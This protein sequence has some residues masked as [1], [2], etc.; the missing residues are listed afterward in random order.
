MIY[1]LLGRLSVG[2]PDREVVLREKYVR[3]LVALM[4]N[5]NHPVS[6]S[7]LLD[8]GWSADDVK[9]AQLDKAI[10]A[11]RDLLRGIGRQAD[12]LTHV[13]IGYQLRVPA[14]QIDVLWFKQLVEDADA[15]ADGQPA[16]EIRLLRAALDLWTGPQILPGGAPD[17]LAGEIRELHFRRRRA[18]VRLF[19]LELARQNANTVVAELYGL[20]SQYPTDRQL[21]ELFMLAAY[22][23]GQ[24]TEAI[25]AY[26]RHAAALAADD[27]AEPDTTTRNLM[28][29]ISAGDD[30]KVDRLAGIAPAAPRRVPRE[31]PIGPAEL[32]GRRDLVEESTWLL[33]RPDATN[34]VVVFSGAAGMGKTALAVHVGHLVRGHFTDGELYAELRDARGRA[35]PADEVLGQFLRSLGETQVPESRSER[36]RIYR[37]IMA[38]RR[39]LVLL[40]DAHDEEQVQELIPGSRECG[41]LVTTRRRLPGIVGAHPAAPLEPLEM[42]DAM[43][44]FAGIVGQAN[45]DPAAIER[46]LALCGGLPLAIWIAAALRVHNLGRSADEVAGRL[47]EHGADGFTYGNRSVARTIGASLAQLDQE[48]QDL[49][50]A[51]GRGQLAT[52][53]GWTAAALGG[54]DPGGALS[55]LTTSFIAM[56]A[57]DGRFR[58]HDLTRDYA[59]RRAAERGDG[60]DTLRRLYGGLLTLLRHAHRSLYG[61]DFEVVHSAVAEWDAPATLLAEAASGSR[62]FATERRNVRAAVEHCA[63]LGLTELCWDLAASAHELYTLGGYFDDW[64][65]THTIALAACR[66][67]GDVRGEGVML[68]MLG[69]PALVASR[70]GGAVSGP[71]DLRRAAQLLEATGDGHGYAIAVRTLANALRRRGQLTEPLRLFT[72]ALRHYRAAGDT[73]GTCMTQRYIGHTLLDMGQSKRALEALTEAREMAAALNSPR[74]LAQTEYWIGQAHLAAGDLDGSQTSFERVTSLLGEVE[75]LGHAYAYHGFG[76]V[77]RLREDRDAARRMYADAVRLAEG[78]A[79]AVLQGRVLLSIATLDGDAG[80]TGQQVAALTQARECFAGCGAAFHEAATW[81]ALARAEA[82]R[83]Q[84]AAAEDAWRQVQHRYAEMSLPEADRIHRPPQV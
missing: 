67:F 4:L 16:E 2:E 26:Q 44:L 30:G 42:T 62:W 18:A 11:V 17:S 57:D 28:Y 24:R 6:R 8:A 70:P 59:A 32:V 43:T 72:D 60:V 78:A 37:S 39:M 52:F 23:T 73:V 71:D 84:A 45:D 81:A 36:A 13:G 66:R 68:T 35:V 34:R 14:E 80:D 61:G 41:V 21:C 83:G 64:Y 40:D 3:V 31:L 10:N 75:G 48:A 79:D 74:V 27:A 53:G 63:D 58:L 47:A 33:T 56:P 12:L 20:A 82:A 7:A 54:A 76:D 29:A 50:L 22:R 25:E 65:T 51:L 69:Q 15:A 19:R 49:F 46:V 55:Q 38:G 5:A 77:A 9:G 1:R